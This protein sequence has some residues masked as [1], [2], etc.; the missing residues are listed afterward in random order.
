MCIISTN[1]QTFEGFVL[2]PFPPDAEVEALLAAC[3][4]RLI[5]EINPSIGTGCIDKAHICDGIPDCSDGTDEVNCPFKCADGQYQC[6]GQV[7]RCIS[8]AKFCDGTSDCPNNDDESECK[9]TCPGNMLA[10]SNGNCVQANKICDGR[11]DCPDNADEN[12]C[13]QH[14][15]PGNQFRCSDGTC[16]NANQ[17]CDATNNCINNEDETFCR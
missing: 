3:E 4:N 2:L 9:S 5:C 10:C 1:C 12:E 13:A 16:V 8:S 7:Q 11:R 15:C 17:L 14:G 6:Q